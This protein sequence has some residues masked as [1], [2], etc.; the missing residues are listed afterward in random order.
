MKLSQ[1][2]DRLRIEKDLKVEER[3][4]PDGIQQFIVWTNFPFPKKHV[5]WYV[6]TLPQ[7]VK[8]E[9]F[10]IEQFQIDAM[11]RHLWMFQL[12]VGDL[13]EEELEDID[14]P[15]LEK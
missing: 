1:L 14:D 11:L 9:E 13:Q 15:Q 2:L 10:E 6:F 7:D 4:D 12:Q 3:I 5:E 8:A